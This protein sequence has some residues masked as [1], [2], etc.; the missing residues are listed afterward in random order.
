MRGGFDASF[1]K[2]P[3]NAGAR[4]F[5]EP[6]LGEEILRADPKI[7]VGVIDNG[8]PVSQLPDSKTVARSLESI[9]FLAVIDP[10]LTDTAEL[11]DVVLPTTTMLEEHDVVGAYGHHHVQLVAGEGVLGAG[12]L[13]VGEPGVVGERAHAVTPEPF[14]E[15]L[16]R[17]A[18][19]RVDDA[20]QATGGDAHAQKRDQQP[21][22]H[23]V[24]PEGA[25]PFDTP[26]AQRRRRDEP[27]DP[28]QERS[29]IRGTEV[30]AQ[31]QDGRGGER[32][33]QSHQD[34]KADGEPEPD[35]D[36]YVIVV[37][38]PTLLEITVDGVNAWRAASSHRRRIRR[39]PAGSATAS[40]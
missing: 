39:S 6:L 22:Q 2:R 13:V 32:R 18:A 10:F 20:G 21:R 9:D 14:R 38:G 30:P 40:T 29:A 34:V 1:V 12:A 23:V 26:P 15:R 31:Q 5:L 37:T 25:D 7:R 24:L 19:Q 33:V 16:D 4:T 8:N 3:E 27:P 17:F 11:A 36:T 28:E 35:V